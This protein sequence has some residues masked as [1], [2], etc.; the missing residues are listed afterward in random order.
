MANPVPL[1]CENLETLL[2]IAR[3]APAD[4]E[5]TV[6]AVHQAVRDIRLGFGSRLGKD[7]AKLISTYPLVDPPVT[8]NDILRATGA[9]A[10]SLWLTI[11]LMQRLPVLFMDNNA[12][13]DTFNDEPITRDARTGEVVAQLKDQLEDL[14]QNM[15]DDDS[16]VNSSV[17]ST[18]NGPDT[19]YILTSPFTGVV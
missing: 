19:P 7:R 14:L 11:L 2:L 6:A 5:N 3:I 9:S 17:K 10:E 13:N 15:A 16:K 8:T 18:I 12:V 1:Y 4:D